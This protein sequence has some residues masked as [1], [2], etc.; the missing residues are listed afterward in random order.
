SD[1]KDWELRVGTYITRGGCCGF[2]TRTWFGKFDKKTCKFLG[3][4]NQHEE[5][6]SSNGP[7][8]H[9]K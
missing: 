4:I 8:S 3:Y 6:N 5:H 7:G 1:R 2:V 9:W